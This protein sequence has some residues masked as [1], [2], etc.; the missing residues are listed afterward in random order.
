MS[1]EAFAVPQEIYSTL[2]DRIEAKIESVMDYLIG[3]PNEEITPGDYSM[4]SSELRDI[5]FRRS[6]SENGDRM[7]KLMAVA[8]SDHSGVQR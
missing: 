7:A 5:R 2:E 1:E 4:L 6:Q 3:K 8:F